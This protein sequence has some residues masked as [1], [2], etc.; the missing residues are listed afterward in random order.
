MVG[1]DIAPLGPLAVTELNNLFD[2][3][4]K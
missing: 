1:S 4:E 3:A 2:W